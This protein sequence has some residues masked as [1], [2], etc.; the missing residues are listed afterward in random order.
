[1]SA[2]ENSAITLPE[3]IA[4]LTTALGNAGAHDVYPDQPSSDH[5]DWF[6]VGFSAH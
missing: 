1:M 3:P 6:N 4:N 5:S 2:L